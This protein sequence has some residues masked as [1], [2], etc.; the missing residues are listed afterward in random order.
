M[1]ISRRIQSIDMVRGLIMVIMAL[2]HTRDFFHMGAM[3]GDATNLATTTPALFLTRWIT[4]FCAPL[5]VFLSGT[6]IY[7]Q[8]TRKTKK[9]LGTFLFT[10][11]LWLVIAELTFIGFGWTFDFS[12][13]FFFL[14]V[15]WAIGLSMIFL[16]ALI[17]LNYRILLSIGIVI[18]F[19][20]NILDGYSFTDP[21]LD[22]A[23]NMFLITEF[24]V[25]SV[26]G[27][28]LM[29]AYAVLPWTGI[30]LLGYALGKLYTSGVTQDFRRKTL[31]TIG[32]SLVVLFIAIRFI[33]IY[34][35]PKPWELQRN[36][37]YTILSFINVT[38]YPPSL[39]YTCMTIGP[40][41]LI[42]AFIEKSHNRITHILNIFGRVPFFYYI[43]HIYVIHLAAALLYFAQGFTFADLY[44]VKMSFALFVPDSDYGVPL[45]YVYIIWIA[46]T[47]VCYL[48]TRW[49]NKYKSSHKNWWLSYI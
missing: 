32:A 44:T 17:F 46:I 24:D 9:E 25:F 6:S 14:Q 31:L 7:L 48:P 45:G 18:T 36:L 37:T 39:L 16:S 10:R 20:H 21:A 28:K 5:F 1:E 40:G 30:M 29:F 23:A 3:T 19:G 4:H 2:D 49:Y 41:L 34:G 33:N 13:N 35:D 42:L 26:G 12:F 15:I 38:K 8:S 27:F 47:A 22:F 11:G 43:L